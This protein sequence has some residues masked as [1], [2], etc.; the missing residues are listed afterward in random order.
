M[1]SEKLLF[2]KNIDNIYWK[3]YT[4]NVFFTFHHHLDV[5]STT[6]ASLLFYSQLQE[7]KKGS[8]SMQEQ[9]CNCCISDKLAISLQL[10]S[11]WCSTDAHF[12]NAHGHRQFLQNIVHIYP[13]TS[14]FSQTSLSSC[15]IFLL[16]QYSKNWETDSVCKLSAILKNTLNLI[17]ETFS[18][19]ES[20]KSY[21]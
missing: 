6:L 8:S 10:K 9:R 12:R 3:S 5:I 7:K 14:Q 20:L 11:W 21:N 16:V 2:W 17:K 13:S 15:S 18:A 1:A 4:Q 19:K